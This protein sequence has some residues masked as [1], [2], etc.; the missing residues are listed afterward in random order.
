METKRKRYSLLLAGCVIVA[1]V[2][3]LVS[4]PRHVQAGQHSRAVLYL[5]IGWLPYTGAFYAAARLFSS[6]AAL[7]NM[8]AA[9]IG[10]GLFLLSLLL[11]LGLDAWGFSPEQIPTAHLLQAIGIFVGLALFGWGIGRRSKSIAGAE[12]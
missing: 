7:P 2:V 6:P 1:A 11:S 9:D 3:Y 5:G 10:L 12:R 4:I 8:R